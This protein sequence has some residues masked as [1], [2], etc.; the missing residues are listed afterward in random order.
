MYMSH[1]EC[2]KCGAKHDP[3]KI[4]QLCPDCSAPLLVRYD[5]A[6][7]KN[8]VTKEDLLGRKP[9]LWR[10]R[11]LLPLV[12][13]RNKV[14]LGEGMTPLLTLDKLSEKLGVSAI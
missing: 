7:V 11:E 12:N 6:K 5:L 8:N 9:D 1:L 3:H 13:D 10:Y 14:S 4:T 2:P